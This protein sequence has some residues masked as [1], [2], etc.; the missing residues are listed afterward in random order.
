MFE[1]R[2]RLLIPLALALA[3]GACANIRFEQGP[4]AIRALEVVYS[5][6]E[7]MTFFSWRLRKD[8]K[9]ALVDFELWQDGDYLPLA[10]DD[11]P[12]PAEPVDCGD[13]WCF[14]YQLPGE[15]TPPEQTSPM[16]SVHRDDGVFMG[17][18]QRTRRVMTTF[19]TDPIALG[20]N[21]GIDPRRYD[22]FAEND[23]PLTRP[24]QWQFTDYAGGACADPAADDWRPSKN[25][26]AVDR[27]WTTRATDGICFHLRPVRTDQPSDYVTDVLLPSAE[28]SFETQKYVPARVNAPIVWGLL[29]DLEIPDET[30]CRQVKGIIIDMLEASI[31]G[32]G[33]DQKLGIYTPIDAETGEE[34]SGC[35]QASSR[36]YPLEQMLRDGQTAQAELEPDKTRVL[37]VFANN[38]EL[39]P[40][41]RIL[42]QLELLGLALLFG[43]GFDTTGFLPEDVPVPED[44]GDIVE[45]GTAAYTWAIGSDVFMGL[46]PWNVTTPWRPI[47]DQTLRADVRATARAT[48]PF[49]TMRHEATTE[50]EITSPKT[51][52]TRP[53]AFKICDATPFGV[54]AIGVEAGLPIWAGDQTVP[55][56]EFDDYPPYFQVEIPPQI[57]VPNSAF[58]RRSE[59][60]VV[61][62]CTAFCNG[63]FR[64][65]GGDDYANWWSGS[66]CQWN[67]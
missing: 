27:A 49:A 7:D 34:L 24:Y 43:E 57:L 6:Q 2:S 22:W 4:Y 55:W 46:F 12:F 60:V 67:Q 53:I 1:T 42:D 17:P 8:A 59:Q 29:L 10:L 44:G 5:A 50:V 61:E 21:D 40:S 15:Y 30:R 20:H 36:E 25:P 52:E 23:V 45:L 54:S 16:R 33:D 13:T 26:I 47:E 14:Q 62:V 56:P 39:P 19:G 9:L 37:W 11:A 35:D 41:Q 63:P 58:V 64:N 48:L 38:I 18:A 3:V 66:I 65:R 32:R 31:G 51:A 28:T